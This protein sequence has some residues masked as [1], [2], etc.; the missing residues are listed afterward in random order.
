MLVQALA[1]YADVYLEKQLADPGF[2]E[3][4]VRCLIEIDESGRFID[5]HERITETTRGTGTKK[6]TCRF[7]ESLMVAKSP[8]NRNNRNRAHPLLA[9][10]A[11][12]Y[13]LGP[14][15]GIWTRADEISKHTLHHSQFVDLIG[16]AACETKDPALE[17]CVAFYADPAQ[18]EKARQILASKKLKGAELVVALSVR[19]SGIDSDNLGGPIIEREAVRQFWRKHYADKLE[20]RHSPGGQGMCLISGKSGPIAVTH[21]KIKGVANLGGRSEVLLMSFDKAAFQSYG[22]EQNANSP[23]SIN[24]SLAYVLAL[25]DLLKPGEHRQGYSR[26]KVLQTRSDYGGVAFLYWTREPSDENPMSIFED[27]QPENLRELLDSPYT[28]V[29]PTNIEGNQFFVLTVSGNGGRLVVHDWIYD[30]LLNVMKNLREW[31]DG[32]QIA[33]VFNYGATSR[34]PSLYQLLLAISPPRV[35][36]WDKVNSDRAIRMARRAL[37]GL[38]LD[39]SILGAALSRLRLAS[40][41]TR[42]DTARIGLIRLCVNDILATKKERRELTESLDPNQD[43]PAYLCGRL[44]AIYEGLQYQALGELNV[45]IADRYYGLAST[46]PQLAFPKLELLSK[47]HLKRLRRDKGAAAH[48]ISQ[49]INDL[50]NKLVPHG[51]KYPAQLNIEDQG[52]FVIGYH[53]QKA[54]DAK[55]REA[56]KRKSTANAKSGDK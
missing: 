5:I 49:R 31:F 22:W 4:R 28:G 2:E 25:N 44:L 1:R 8:V 7:A 43:N 54:E 24:R 26:E 41:K 53:H 39:Y 20:E 35:K 51:A 14:F 50:T 45:S 38:P 11:I 17:A 42:H 29:A 52:R 47:A 18:V 46:Y 15:P 23:V 6:K 16:R 55:A 30:S 9:C 33:D 12:Q 34:L 3:K 40:G 32:L 36:P 13:V 48:A 19:P 37:Y 27:P 10:D 56:R 21:D